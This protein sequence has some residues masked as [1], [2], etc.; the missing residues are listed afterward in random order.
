M[1][2]KPLRVLLKDLAEGTPAAEVVDPAAGVVLDPCL[3][4]CAV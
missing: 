1:P 2:P 3:E 4:G